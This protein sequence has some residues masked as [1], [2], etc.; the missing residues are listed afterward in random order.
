M[1]YYTAL[2]TKWNTL[3][4][5]TAQKLATINSLTIAAPQKAILTPS[6]IINAIAPADLAALSSAQVAMLTLLLQ[7]SSIDASVGTTIR[8]AAQN[9]FA[10]KATTLAALGALVA[11]YDNATIPWW[12]ATVAQGGGGLNSSVSDN[13]LIAAGGL[14]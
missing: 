4:G 12:Q 7:G 9:I 11:P 3:S 6:S 14:V 10:G 8:L 1:A 13:D 2:I 5:T